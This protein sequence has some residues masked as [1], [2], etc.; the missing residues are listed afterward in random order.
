MV[1]RV[2]YNNKAFKIINDYGYKFSNNEVTFN[3]IKID[4]TGCSLADIPFKYQ[5]IKIMQANSESEILN[6]EILFTGYLDDIQFS[7]MQKQKEF[8]EITLTLLSPLKM[9]TKRSTSL[10]GTYELKEAI[11]RVIQPLIDDGFVLVDLNV[12]DGQITTNYVLETV[13]NE[14]NDIGFKRNIFWYINHK[15]EIYV[16]S[17]D[18]LFG[19]PTKSFIKTGLLKILPTIESVDYAN[20][21]NFKNVRIFYTVDNKIS[22][23][24]VPPELRMEIK[25]PLINLP[26][27]LKNGDIITFNNPIVIDEATLRELQD[28]GHADSLVFDPC[29]LL[30]IYYP[31]GNNFFVKQVEIGIDKIEGNDFNK[32]V[33]RGDFSYSDSAGEEADIVLQKDNFYS[34]LITGFKWNGPDGA[35]I[36]SI[37]SF[38]A[39]RYTTMRFMYSAEIDK[40][41]GTISDSGQIEK[42]IDYNNKWTTLQQLTTYARSLMVQNSNIINQITLEYDKNPEYQIGEI[43]NFNDEEFYLKGKYAV[44]SIDYTYEN[45]IKQKWKITLKTTDLISSFIDLFR[46]AEKQENVET[47][48]TVIISE[49]IEEEINEKHTIELD[50]E[51][52]TLNFNLEV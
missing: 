48:N 2:V 45:K 7:D 12:P 49:F 41:K 47:V 51:V 29:L 3:D 37:T 52:H 10:I 42:T 5:E 38:T 6:G 23:F 36:S 31:S 24:N 15:K 18:Y 50:N 26:K 9:A 28:V 11:R 13:E 30:N 8:R 4:F 39:L 34:N 22:Y 17:I 46:P 20:V 16:N 40:L 32:F 21:I 35:Y 44:K 33:E 25:Y 19:Q 43:I 14:M 27:T 1:T